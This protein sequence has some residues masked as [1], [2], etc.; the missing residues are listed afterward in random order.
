MGVDRLEASQ[1]TAGRRERPIARA[2]VATGSLEADC[3]RACSPCQSKSHMLGTH[4]P[5][6]DGLRTASPNAKLASSGPLH[7]WFMARGSQQASCTPGSFPSPAGSPCGQWDSTC[8]SPLP[9]QASPLPTSGLS[10][11]H[12]SSPSRQPPQAFLGSQGPYE[13]TGSL[14]AAVADTNSSSDAHV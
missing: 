12:T 4:A 13:R 6:P 7:N 8:N 14:S 11:M 1:S 9:T 3:N 5:S 10:S 2:L